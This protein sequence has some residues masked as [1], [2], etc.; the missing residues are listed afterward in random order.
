MENCQISSKNPNKMS[1]LPDFGIRSE[2][3]IFKLL[4]ATHQAVER[5][6]QGDLGS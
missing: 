6:D 3:L 1:W 2:C 5:K 4:R